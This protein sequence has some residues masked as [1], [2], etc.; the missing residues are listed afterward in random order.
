MYVCIYVC[1]MFTSKI[2]LDV[3]ENI[4]SKLLDYVYIFTLC[5]GVKWLSQVQSSFTV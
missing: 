2:L 3:Q 4:L 1:T 5:M